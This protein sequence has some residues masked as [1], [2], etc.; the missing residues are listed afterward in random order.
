ME[1][2]L[3]FIVHQTPQVHALYRGTGASFSKAQEEF[4]KG[5]VTNPGVQ[6]ATRQAAASAVSGATTSMFS[7]GGGAAAGNNRM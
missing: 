2:I 1:L 3:L 6:S 5:V 4:A 7:S